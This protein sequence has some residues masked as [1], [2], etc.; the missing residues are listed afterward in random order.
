MSKPGPLHPSRWSFA[1]TADTPKSI[2]DPPGYALSKQRE[3]IP[4]SS[5]P[6]VANRGILEK[7]SAIS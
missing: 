4:V 6:S 3:N 7:V 5:K 2:A 1:T